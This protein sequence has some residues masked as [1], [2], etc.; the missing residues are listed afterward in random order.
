MAANDQKSLHIVMFPWL[1]FGHIIPY[2]DLSK[3]IAQRGHRISFV[4]SPRNIDRLPKLPPHLASSIDLVKIPL[5]KI[6]E[7]PENAEATMDIHVAQMGHLKKAYD[8]L[9]AGLTSFLEDT[10]PDWIFYDFAPHWLPPIAA[11]LGISRAFFSIINACCL[12]FYGPANVLINGSDDRTKPEDF[13]VPPKWVNLETK[14]AYRR[15]EAEWM[16]GAIQKNDSGLPDSYRMGNVIDGSQAI[17]VKHCYEF[18]P[19]WLTLLEGLYHKPVVP[20]GLLPPKV[21]EDEDH[22]ELWVAIQNWL[23]AQNKGSVIYVALGSEVVPS[24]DQLTELAYGLELSGVPFFYV[25]RK[26]SRSTDSDL[27]ELPDGFEERVT[28]RGI[29]WRNWAPQLKI[30]SHESVG[31]FL[32]HCG[33]CSI[34]EAL[35]FGLPLIRL[36]FLADQGLNSRVIANK[37]LGIEIPR[38]EEDG[39]YTRNSV[40]DSIKLV[41]LEDDGRKFRERAK[42]M[43]KIFGD[44]E[45]HGRYIDRLVEFLRN[46]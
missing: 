8:G 30:L 3:L 25:L 9:E 18:E 28:G 33:W 21:Q 36:P 2:L 14:V 26:P 43:S 10:R 35:M 38:N 40:A 45:L 46:H 15:F 1:A 5:P 13:T 12:G 7:L 20:V 22:D 19:D 24:Q 42:E 4:S 23:D 17:L 16:I 29:V 37:Q 27:V 44:R 39:S 32:T 11:R 6:A 34:I 31:G 41:M